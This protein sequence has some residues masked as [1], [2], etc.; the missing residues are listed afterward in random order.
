VFHYQN[1]GG[2]K[3]NIKIEINYSMRHHILP[4]VKRK[5]NA[6]ILHTD[7]EVRTLATLELFG[8]KIKALIER[9]APRDLY[10]IHN[11]LVQNIIGSN[12]QDML[13]KIVLFYL[14]TGG[15]NKLSTTFNFDSL[16]HLKFPEIRSSL[17][18]VLRKSEHFDF[19]TAKMKICDYLS[20]LMLPTEKERLYVEN[21]NR[22]FYQPE[23]FFDETDI[24]ERI[25]E[26]PMALWKMNKIRNL[27]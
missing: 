13:R 10:D 19:E 5:I 2:N 21:F 26:H 1:T 6:N 14:S 22:G 17:I 4:T 24:I 3:D 16:N 9:T 7:F 23:L 15:K 18:P 25:K 20:T 12:E 8:S 11:M 27:S